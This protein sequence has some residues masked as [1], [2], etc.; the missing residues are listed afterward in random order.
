LEAILLQLLQKT[1]AGSARAGR[2][3]LNY[4]AFAAMR[5]TKSTEVGYVESDYSQTFSNRSSREDDGGL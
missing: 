1:L 5:S 2:A 4:Q 3:L